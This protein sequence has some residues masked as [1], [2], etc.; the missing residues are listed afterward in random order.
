MV[1]AKI[2]YSFLFGALALGARHEVDPYE[3][4]RR[5][6]AVLQHFGAPQEP[7]FNSEV[8]LL[9][10]LQSLQG[11]KERLRYLDPANMITRFSK[12][13]A[14]HTWPRLSF[15]EDFH[16]KKVLDF[17]AE[18]SNSVQ[19][20]SYQRQ[21]L[22]GVR[23]AL[24]PGH[25]GGDIW[26]FRTG[27]FVQNRK[28]ER[29]SEGLLALQTALLLE[30]RLTR[31]GA[32]VLL[33]RRTLDSVEK[34]RYEDL[35]LEPYAKKELLES[36]LQ[37]WFLQTLRKAPVGPELFAAFE[38][39]KEFRQL[40]SEGMRWK[41]FIHGAD[42][43]ARA[44]MINNFRP[45]VALCLHFDA[46]TKNNGLSP[47]PLKLTKTYIAGGFEPT[48]FASRSDRALF[49]QHAL[50]KKIWEESRRLSRHIVSQI[51]QR[52]QMKPETPQV[53]TTPEIEKGVIARNLALTRHLVGIPFSYVESFY[54]NDKDEFNAL[55]SK[56]YVISID[57]Q[58]YAYSK[59][60]LDLVNAL[61]AAIISYVSEDVSIQQAQL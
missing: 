3:M 31:R 20:T 52:L 29:L 13:E 27:K 21:S 54:Y 22:N 16:S 35:G 45:D 24:D 32:Q 7:R 28:G 18:L 4:Y 42:L 50:N 34:T 17:E 57:G 19:L 37:P 60:L 39:R 51:S 12:L 8:A 53:S 9:N 47:R 55:K 49:A 15:F 26:D 14:H 23:I 1:L 30:E 38:K 58:P 33:T 36:T 59:R 40:F 43:E 46:A 56:D 48:E 25:M 10:R 6:Q 2:I 11:L 5:T 41:Y 61:E 44:Q